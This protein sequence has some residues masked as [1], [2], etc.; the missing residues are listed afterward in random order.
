MTAGDRL[1]AISAQKSLPAVED[2]EDRAVKIR[3]A[4]LEASAAHGTAGY[5][6][7]G[8][9]VVKLNGHVKEGSQDTDIF[10]N[11]ENAEVKYKVLTWW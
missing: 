11:E 8:E 10:G 2:R 4:M 6:D 9:G 3:R 7:K 1:F 5:E